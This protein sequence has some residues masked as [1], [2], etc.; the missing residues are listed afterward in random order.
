MTE[1]EVTHKYLIFYNEDDGTSDVSLVDSYDEEIT[2]EYMNFKILNQNQDLG[3]VKLKDKVQL[4]FPFIGDKSTIEKVKPAC[5]C[6]AKVEVTDNEIKAIF[7]PEGVGP[8]SK[9]INVYFKDGTDLNLVNAL[10]VE[11]L[12]PNKKSI[13]LKFH[14]KVEK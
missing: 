13:K 4:S 12:N 6:T 8:F 9:G 14:G 5:G 1:P 7:T 2:N 3:T 10:G 11:T